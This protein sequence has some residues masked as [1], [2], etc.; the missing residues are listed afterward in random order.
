M[1]KTSGSGKFLAGDGISFQ[2]I[3]NYVWVLISNGM[4]ELWL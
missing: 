1:L 2:S 4:R 3:F